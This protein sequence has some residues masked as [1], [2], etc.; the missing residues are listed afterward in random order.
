MTFYVIDLAT[1]KKAIT[2]PFVTAVKQHI[3]NEF[4]VYTPHEDNTFA[5]FETVKINP[6][7]QWVSMNA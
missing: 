4:I 6:E 2:I 3:S 5:K 7:T 1:G